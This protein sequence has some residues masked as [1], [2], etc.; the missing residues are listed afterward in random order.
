M[1]APHH[2]LPAPRRIV[3]SNLSLPAAS[4]SDGGA[5]P[6][7]EVKVDALEA[8]PILG[9]SLVRY[10]VGTNTQVPTSNDGQ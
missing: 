6:G 10:T 2:D 8:Q 4:A 1:S 7:V 9:G 3:A 5:E